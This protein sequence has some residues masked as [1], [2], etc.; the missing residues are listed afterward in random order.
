MTD[1][2]VAASL[3]ELVALA[4]NYP[5]AFKPEFDL[6][7]WAG[8]EGAEPWFVRFEGDIEE[9]EFTVLGFSAAEALRKAKA[10]AERRLL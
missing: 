8:V 4:D 9:N 1:S 7:Y 6:G 5:G 3:A 10:E 2:D